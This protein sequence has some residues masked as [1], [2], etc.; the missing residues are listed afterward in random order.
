[1]LHLAQE[2]TILIQAGASGLGQSFASFDG[3]QINVTVRVAEWPCNMQH[4]ANNTPA[5]CVSA[6]R[7]LPAGAASGDYRSSPAL[8]GVAARALS[9]AV[10]RWRLGVCD[11][12]RHAA[13]GWQVRLR[14][15]AQPYLRA[16]SLWLNL[17]QL[18]V[19]APAM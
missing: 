3:S 18:Q 2:A 7:S 9:A 10:V 16:S 19:S 5:H 14:V 1:M 15:S 12:A 17:L 8:V 11:V 13:L 4:A 6:T